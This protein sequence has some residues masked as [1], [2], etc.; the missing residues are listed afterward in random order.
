VL[1]LQ[2]DPAHPVT[3]GFLCYRTNRF[4]AWRQ[5]GGG[6]ILAPLARRSWLAAVRAGGAP[7]RQPPPRADDPLEETSWDEALD[8]IARHLLRVRGESGPAAILNYRSG[9]SL[10][11]LKHLT[12]HLFEAFGPTAV[13][14]GDICS[15]AGEAAQEAD[16]GVSDSHALSDL[17]NAR[18]IVLWGKNPHVSNV[19]LLP[20][21]KDAKAAGA[22]LACIDPVRHRGADLADLYLQPRPGGDLALAMAVAR[23]LFEGG[24]LPADIADWCDGV[25]GLRALALGRELAAWCADADVSPDQARA[26]AALLVD[27]PTAILVGWGMQRRV[28]GAAIVRALDALG[29]LS[30]NLGIPGGGVS[31]YFQRRRAFDTDF[32]RGVGAAPRT[33]LEPLLGAELLEARAPPYRAVWVSCGNPVAMLPDSHAVARAM[34]TR[35]LLVVVDSHETDTTRR[36]TVVLPCTTMLEDED[37]VGAYGHHYL[38]SVRRVVPPPPG[39]RTDLEILQELAPRL[40]LGDL[41]AGDARAWKR[42]LLGRAARAGAT[43]E[44][45]EDGV[46][47][48]PG[49]PQVL[50]AGRRFP[51]PTG[52]MRV[53]TELPVAPEPCDP[54]FDLWLMS[55]STRRAQ[56]SQWSAARREHAGVA[57]VHPETARAR[58]LCDG[59]RASLESAVGRI[60]VQVR[61]D[62]GQRRDV[63]LLPKGGWLDEGACANALVP[64]RATDL[65]G[66]AAY[67]DARVRMKAVEEADRG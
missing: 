47:R 58:G 17:R 16:F 25:A 67:Q 61:T 63:V 33:A 57:T 39:V 60:R 50:F 51:T 38:G 56:S 30:G 20:V 10:G 26:L 3:R 46:V 12:D 40:G 22:Q 66:G 49:A 64:A 2:G 53:L 1:R 44:A 29:A 43:L 9:G 27:G 34:E 41:L 23:C 42:R 19:H 31:F 21:L 14:R 36:A 15:G 59:D 18:G 37:L 5:H 54:R 13:K 24:R 48:A 45:I 32:I 7:P 65:G 35:E 52:R 55:S 6:R 4:L 62:P 11:L 8:G 28:Q